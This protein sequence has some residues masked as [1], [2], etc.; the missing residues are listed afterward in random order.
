MSI[1]LKTTFSQISIHS[2]LLVN[3]LERSDKKKASFKAIEKY[4]YGLWKT[5]SK[6]LKGLG[7][8]DRHPILKLAV[9]SKC[10]NSYLH[11]HAQRPAIH[12]LA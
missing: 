6:H 5:L 3:I 12:Q 8:F 9:T 10:P 1:L 4:R 2:Q 7:L 11:K